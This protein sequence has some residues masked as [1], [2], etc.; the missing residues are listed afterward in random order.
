M[1]CWNLNKEKFDNLNITFPP[2]HR[3]KLY[4][5]NQKILISTMSGRLRRAY[6]MGRI[7]CYWDQLKEVVIE[8]VHKDNTL[9]V[10]VDSSNLKRKLSYHAYTYQRNVHVGKRLRVMLAQCIMSRVHTTS[11]DEL[12][13]VMGLEEV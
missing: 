1:R 4:I 7:H 10:D 9:P 6:S 12:G 5:S 13:T 8:A 11:P 2:H 3:Q